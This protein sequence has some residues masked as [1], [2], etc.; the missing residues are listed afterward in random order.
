M[1]MLLSETDSNFISQRQ[2]IF[3]TNMN[4]MMLSEVF[5]VKEVDNI[6]LRAKLVR[7]VINMVSSGVIIGPAIKKGNYKEKTC[8]AAV[9][10]PRRIFGC[11]NTYEAF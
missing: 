10:L 11:K 7:N 6:S 5:M 8:R 9:A 1:M 4:L 2:S 3:A